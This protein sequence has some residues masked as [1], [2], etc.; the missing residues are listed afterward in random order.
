MY[1]L[2][3]CRAARAAYK[4]SA[5]AMTVAHCAT[6]N[7]GTARRR[8]GRM[9]NASGATSGNRPTGPFVSAAPATHSPEIAPPIPYDHIDDRPL[10]SV[11]SRLRTAAVT[12]TH[13]VVSSRL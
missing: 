5:H 9:P 12:N 6:V 2:S 3:P 7:H 11:A 13:T 1:A 4:T 8:S 10:V